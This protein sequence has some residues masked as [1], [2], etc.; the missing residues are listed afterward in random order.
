[1]AEEV[2]RVAKE[3]GCHAVTFSENPE[4]LDD[5]RPPT[6][7]AGIPSAQA[8][9][10]QKVLSSAFHGSS[11]QVVVTSIDDPVDRSSPCSP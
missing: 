3:E 1:M 11:F 5:L 2:R 4:K 8:C 7:N 6:A 10:E 9:G